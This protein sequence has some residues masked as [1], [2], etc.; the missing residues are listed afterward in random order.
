M[1]VDQLITWIVV[2]GIA[3]WLA[4]AVVRGIR[5][6]LAGTV[7]V[8]IVGAFVGGW[9][10]RQLNVAIQLGN[11]LLTNIVTAFVG[12]VILLAILRGVR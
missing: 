9:L 3:G 1:T 5:L 8:G 7:L 11:P 10:F 4:K 2:G 12:A 6:G